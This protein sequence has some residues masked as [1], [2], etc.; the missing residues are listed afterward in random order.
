MMCQQCHDRPAEYHLTSVVEGQTVAELHLCEH[1]AAERGVAPQGAGGAE[2]P[3]SM[4]GWLASLL[5][6]LAEAPPTSAPAGLRCARCGQTYQEFSRTGLLGCPECYD[7]FS[8]ALEPVIR[9]V[10]G[11]SEHKGK[12]PARTGGPIAQ[13]RAADAL[14]RE[15]ETAVAQQAFERAAELRDRIR[16]LDAPGG[17]A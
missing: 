9:R 7:R 10:Q 3:L 15:L 8:A 2:M 17:K 16:A 11:K 12:V 14:R 6:G 5:A 13:R 1:C 4:Q